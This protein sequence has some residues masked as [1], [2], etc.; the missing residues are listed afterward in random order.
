MED[1]RFQR[2]KIRRYS[3]HTSKTQKRS[4]SP[5]F[6][7]HFLTPINVLQ[8]VSSPVLLFLFGNPS[9]HWHS[10]QLNPV[11]SPAL[12]LSNWKPR[13]REMLLLPA[14]QILTF[15]TRC[16]ASCTTPPSSNMKGFLWSS[17]KTFQSTTASNRGPVHVSPLCLARTKMP[18]ALTTFS[19]ASVTTGNRL[20]LLLG[21]VQVHH[22]HRYCPTLTQNQ[23]I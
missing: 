2:W 5:F 23:P 22:L 13:R 7:K 12:T 3:W 17:W 19:R 9:A 1:T 8:N 15:M 14:L 6:L 20:R 11:P 18:C 16:G 21:K 10:L 4:F